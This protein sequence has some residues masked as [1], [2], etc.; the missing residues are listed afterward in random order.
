MSGCIGDISREIEALG[1]SD[2]KAMDLWRQSFN[3][4][5]PHEALQMRCPGE[6]YSAS[7]R[8]I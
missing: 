2:Q 5:R 1:Q 4:E 8:Q 7:E 3:Y 6:V